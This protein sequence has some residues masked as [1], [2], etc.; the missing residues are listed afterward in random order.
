MGSNPSTEN[1]MHIFHN[2]L[3]LNCIACLQ[4]PKIN[5]KEVGDGPP[6]STIYRYV[7]NSAQNF[8]AHPMAAQNW[9]NTFFALKRFFGFLVGEGLFQSFKKCFYENVP[10]QEKERSRLFEQPHKTDP[11]PL[12][13]FLPLSLSL[14][15]LLS[16]YLSLESIPL[17]FGL[18]LL[19]FSF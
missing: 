8:L 2:N 1:C 19:H 4:R 15:L 6:L 7:K 9:S 12:S 18:F 17:Y 3:L 16:P 14:F 5:E 10:R 13:L 11:P